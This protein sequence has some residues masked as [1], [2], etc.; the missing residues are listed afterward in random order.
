MGKKLAL[1]AFWAVTFVWFTTHFGGGFASGRQLVDYY[2]S[3]GWYAVFTPVIAQLIEAFV[4][5]YA[6][7]YSIAKR[8]FEYRKWTNEFYKPYEKVFSNLYEIIYNLI[9]LTATAVAFATGGAT[10]AQVL[11]TNYILNTVIIAVVIFLLTIFGVELVKK[12]AS[13]M[14]IVI[15]A[16]LLIIYLSN[17]VVRFPELSKVVSSAP[18]PQGFWAAIWK[19]IVYAGYQCACVGAYIAVAG[20]LKD[21]N[22]A[23]KSAVWGFIINAGLLL[24]ATLVILSFYPAINKETVPVLYVIKN[25]AGGGWAGGIVSRLIFLGVVSTGVNLIYGGTKRLVS[26]WSKGDPS[27]ETRGKNVVASGIYVLITWGIA[28][29]GLIPL[30][31]QGYKYIGYI[32]LPIVIIP[33]LFR[34][35]FKNDWHK[36]DS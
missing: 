5:Y 12:A 34:G 3:Y 15:I 6:W 23:K 16:S 22:D 17:L 21:S 18:S 26:I 32:S 2:V 4:F 9:L 8:L 14:A 27:K 11:G 1:P 25:G 19:S 20:D 10:M 30:I 13:T 24:L 36:Q 35:I 29:F 7:D 28:L 31:S 33:I